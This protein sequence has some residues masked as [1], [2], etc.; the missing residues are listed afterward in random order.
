MIKKILV[1]T[2]G[3]G[4]GTVAARYGISLAG[5]LQASLMGLH[6]LDSRMLEG[7][8]MADISGWI[9]AQPYGAQLQQFREL[10]QQRGEAVI[11]AFNALCQESGI[12]PESWVKMGHPS[13]VI[14]DEEIRAELIVIGQKGEHADLMGDMVGSNADRIVRNSIK[15]CMVVGPV[16]RPITRILVA[17]D[18]SAHASQALQ[19]AVELAQSLEAPLASVTVREH[20]HG[21]DPER[22][23]ADCRTLCKAH[24]YPLETIIA[25]GDPTEAIL[26]EVAARECDLIVAGAHGHG[27]IHE[28][29]IGSVATRLITTS[30]LPVMLVQ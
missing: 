7:P 21:P 16:F 2:D 14:L 19:V 10:M 18:G 20:N 8:L 29:F 26:A 1:C 28:M 22:A 25:D 6:V 15:P 17:Y 11:E 12:T 9:G 24:G 27:R 13:R 4:H 30:D 23:V 3:S 5:K